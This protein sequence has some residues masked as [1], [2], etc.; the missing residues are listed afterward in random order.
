LERLSVRAEAVTDEATA[1]PSFELVSPL[2][3]AAARFPDAA[4]TNGALL[5][6]ETVAGTGGEDKTDANTDGGT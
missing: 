3:V 2:S 6:S 4:E 5:P 1:A